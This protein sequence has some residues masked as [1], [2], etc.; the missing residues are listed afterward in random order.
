MSWIQT[1]TGKKFDVRQP[2]PEDVCWMDIAHSLSQQ[3]RFNGH[4]KHFYSVAQHCWIMSLNV[5]QEFALY[6]LLHDAAEAYIGDMPA[7]VKQLF[8]EFSVMEDMLLSCIYK[9]A[10]IPEPSAEALAVVKEYD[11]RMLMT[12]RQQLLGEPPEPWLLDGM[13]IK[14]LDIQIVLEEPSHVS[15]ED[16]LERLAE[17]IGGGR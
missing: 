8:P 13:G 7:P 14:P 11:L 3:C 6:A 15:A 16:Y 10:G 9:A 12:E 2:R 17:L 5:P 1:Y 4:T